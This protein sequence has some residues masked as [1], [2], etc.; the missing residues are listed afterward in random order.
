[1]ADRIQGI[2]EEDN[3]MNKLQRAVDQYAPMIA[4]N[5]NEQ[6]RRRESTLLREQQDL[7][8]REAA[9]NDRLARIREATEHQELVRQQAAEQLAEEQRQAAEDER[10]ATRDSEIQILRDALL[11]KAEEQKSSGLET[12]VVRFHLPSGKKLTT[13]F[14]KSDTT[15]HVFNFVRVH[16]A[17]EGMPEMNF[18]VST[19]FPKMEL[20]DMEQTIDMIGL[21]P[22]GMLYVQ[23][24]D[25]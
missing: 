11:A 25:A 1:M 3:L 13:N 5:I 15:Q 14:L 19:H 16:F 24:L 12:A 7:E 21:F 9:E 18:A 23:D 8:Y 2:V 6:N 17:D 22:R 20:T 10:I 4:T